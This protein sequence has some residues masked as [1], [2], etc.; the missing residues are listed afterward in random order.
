MLTVIVAEYDANSMVLSCAVLKSYRIA[1]IFGADNFTPSD[2]SDSR[3]LRYFVMMMVVN[4]LLLSLYTV[5]NFINGGSYIR[6][7]VL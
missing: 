5:F 6:Y 2:L 1:S 3:L 4:V 7:K